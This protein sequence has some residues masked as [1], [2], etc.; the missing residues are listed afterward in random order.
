M[1]NVITSLFSSLKDV[2]SGVLN[3][4][5]IAAVVLL[6]G[7][8]FGKVI[9]RIVH[10]LL[11]EVELDKFFR[12]AGLKISVEEILSTFVS[13][14]IYFFSVVMA[15]DQLGLN[16]L[17]FNTL[18]IGVMAI[19]AASVLLAIKD[20]IPNIFAGLVIHTKHLLRKGDRIRL[21]N[22][23]GK[24]SEVNLIETKIETR[25][26]DVVFIP[27]SAVLKERIVRL[28]R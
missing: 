25:T 7:F 26:G 5:V 20:T 10:K 8:I 3:R 15:L 11:R 12:S 2:L 27:N 6:L 24:I 19:I 17:V 22:F 14:M 16:T 13:Y 18:A 21:G 23:K 4:V 28:K 9:G 1:A